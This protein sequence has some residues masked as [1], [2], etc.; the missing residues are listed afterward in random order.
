MFVWVVVTV[1][2]EKWLEAVCT[3][4]FEGQTAYSSYSKAGGSK[5][6]ASKDKSKKISEYKMLQ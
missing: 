2:V 5:R 4:K 3:R 1:V 6:P